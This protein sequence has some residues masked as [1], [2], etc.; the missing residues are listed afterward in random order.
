LPQ[1]KDRQFQTT[2]ESGMPRRGHSP[3]HESDF[4]K[5]SGFL[6]AENESGVGGDIMAKIIE[7]HVP[8]TYHKIAKWVPTERRG[9]V[10]EFSLPKKTA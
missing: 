4:L 9:R 6:L 3:G 7:F 8:S 1:Q 2:L 5:Q 10:L